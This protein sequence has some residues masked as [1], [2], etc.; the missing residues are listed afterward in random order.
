M[1][2]NLRIS[3]IGSNTMAHTQVIIAVELCRIEQI[4][5]DGSSHLKKLNQLR[6]ESSMA[7]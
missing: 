2:L 7:A 4:K 3:E 5:K 1:E 6:Y